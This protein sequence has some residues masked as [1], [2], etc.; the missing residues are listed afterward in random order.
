MPAVARLLSHVARE[1]DAVVLGRRA[2]EDLACLLDR[3]HLRIALPDDEPEELVLDLACGN[4]GDA[5]PA[6][7]AGVAAEAD[8][9]RHVGGELLD[10]R[11]LRVGRDLQPAM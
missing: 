1:A 5:L 8:L 4:V 9:G 10:E 7:V 3:A 2:I 11:D 6:G